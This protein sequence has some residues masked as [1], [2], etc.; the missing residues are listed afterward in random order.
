MNIAHIFWSFTVGGAETMAIDIINEQVRKN[1]VTLIVINKNYSLKLLES[2]D[3]KVNICLLDRLASSRTLLPFCK[4][5]YLLL[6]NGFN[7]I[8]CHNYNLEKII[9]SFFLKK[10]IVTI[11]GFNRPINHT[12]KYFKVVA[13]S[14][15]IADDLIKKGLNNVVI[16]FNGVDTKKIQRKTKF[17]EEM[18]LGCIGRLNHE[19]KGQDIVLKAF[20]LIKK[21]KINV[22]LIFIGDG[23]SKLFLLGLRKSLGLNNNVEFLDSMQR[24]KLYKKIKDFDLLIQ[25]SKHEGFGLTAVEAMSAG[26]PLIVSDAAG[27]VEVTAAGKYAEIF[28]PS[29]PEILAEKIINVIEGINSD[30]LNTKLMVAS[31]YVKS[32]FSIES[33]CANYEDVYMQCY[34]RKI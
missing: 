21:E 3:P 27:L 34:K 23:P 22:K 4:L 13:I 30:L 20:K 15:V 19:V 31:K 7:V 14:K 28:S 33:T 9:F 12:N 18:V 32:R 11:H 26:V 17:N 29:T 16:I 6:K 25:P 24:E 2:L 8:H 10:T 1:K 5:N